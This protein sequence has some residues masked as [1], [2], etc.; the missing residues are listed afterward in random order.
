[1]L[2]TLP[3]RNF[4]LFLLLLA[5]FPIAN[6]QQAEPGIIPGRILFMIADGADAYKIAADL[7]TVDGANTT[8]QIVKEVSAPMRIW[9]MQFDPEAVAQQ[10]MLDA[11]KRHRLVI[12]AQNDHPATFRAVP[13]DP[14][15]ASQWHHQNIDSEAAWNVTTGGTT[16]DGDEIVV[17]VIEA[18]NLL[19]ADLVGNRWVNTQEVANNGIDDDGN[20][21]IDDYDGWNPGANN[22]N[23]LFG[24]SHG[25]NVAGMIGAKGNNGAGVAGAN[26][27][28]KIMVVTVGSLSQSNVIASYTYPL[29]QRRR[30]NDSNGTQGAFV[31][32]T[33]ASWGIDGGDPDDYPLWCAIYDTLG[34]EGVLNCG[35]TSNSNVNVDVV[36]DLPTACSS[37]FM[38]SVTATN[39]SDVRTFSGYGAT[40]ID[41]GAPGENVV[42]T[43][44]TTSGSTSTTS[45]SGT[46]FASPLTAGVIGLLYSVP[47]ASMMDLVKSD[48]SAG[49][50][51]I[52]Q[53][54]FQGVEQVGN[55]PGQTV[56][57]GRIN[58]NNSVQLIV[59]ECSSMGCLPPGG[60]A[61]N[62][63]T[64]TSVQLTWTGS[65]GS[66][67]NLRYRAIGAAQW[68]NVNGL[69]TASYTLSGLAAC[70]SFEF[71]VQRICS[72]TTSNFSSPTA[73]TLS[74]CC[75]P[76]TIE[77][78]TDR[79]GQETTWSITNGTT[80]FA[81]GGPYTQMASNGAYVKPS[82]ELCLPDGCYQLVVN[83]SYGDGI[84]CAYGNGYVR[85]KDENGNVLANAATFTYQANAPF[86]V[87][88]SIKAD[89][90][91][92]LQ[93]PY[94]T[95]P[96]MSDALRSGNHIPLNEPYSAMGL[97][98]GG[99]AIGAGVLAVTGNNAIVDWIRV[100]LRSD[101]TTIVTARHGLLQRDGDIVDVDGTSPL[102]FTAAPGN[103]HVAVKHRNHLGCM[104]ASPI[105]ISG[106]AA[107]ID[108][109]TS[110]T[111]TYGTDA[112]YSNGTLRALWA[113]NTVPD[114]QLKYT[115][116]NNDRDK[117]LQQ[118][119]GLVPTNSVSGYHPADVNLDGSVRYT[120]A[121]NDRDIILQNIGGT[122]P[123]NVR[124]QQ[125]P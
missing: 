46:S 31:V 12:L 18:A 37:P 44:G 65:A 22:D 53:K 103:Y 101:A 81:T 70:G 11:V 6:A 111:A 7:R 67:Y 41:V 57:G 123:T 109:R 2:R 113:G 86:C 25:T 17:C 1:M 29:I 76:V 87:T 13:N 84:C 26:W 47:C 36:G 42:T 20:G 98:G 88:S 77:I 59:N 45:T 8:A 96:V 72:G 54:L 35:A 52:R 68:T 4:G 118:I 40:T 30:Y 119:G 60:S 80:T 69:S 5:S 27:N 91:V 16:A 108:L 14:G 90:K 10:K 51:Y 92:W 50:L 95:G 75:T 3:F 121:S 82:V 28:V 9:E 93:G 49:A 34:T 71:Q 104:T 125:V 120:G 32:A 39:S 85:V 62:E 55:L 24:G 114:Q 33:N 63:T 15:Y 112:R 116:Q 105:A 122:I 107:T 64:P 48:P 23:N 73:W 74:G 115:G 99:E 83:D 106:T 56:T 94:G 110:A 78:A 66:Q 102:S 38:V 89:V 117:I 21:Y 58:A 100:E 79:Y 43:S 124:T 19:H 97:S 61:V